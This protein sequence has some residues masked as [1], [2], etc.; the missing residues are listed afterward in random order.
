M[1]ASPSLVTGAGG[2]IGRALATALRASG[3]PVRGVL[4]TSRQAPV[5]ELVTADLAT[6]E[7]DNRLMDGIDTVYHLAAKTHDLTDAAGV[8]S[9]YQRINVEG[10]RRLLACIHG[11]AIRRFVFISSVKAVGEGGPGPI[12]DDAPARPLTAYGRSKLEAEH[13]VLDH[14]RAH[15]FEAVVLRFPLVYG[16]GQR[17]NL[18]RMIGS[19]ERGWFPVPPA[20]RNRRS[21]LHVENAVDA[22]R[23][24]GAHPSAAGQTYT[25]ADARPYETREIYDL[26]RQALGMSPA[27]WTV[28]ASALR[29]AAVAGDLARR[30][31]GRRVGFDSDAL[32]KLLGSAWYRGDRITRDLGFV[33]RR[34]LPGSIHSLVEDVRGQR[35]S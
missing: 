11:R 31:V 15:G 7:P 32:Q 28:P 2:F 22:L 16:V 5:D 26:I 3:I 21:M 8:E 24:A 23:L 13:L 9:E 18:Q 34:D 19:I 30:V 6:L 4:R 17:G 14:A 33:P 27:S 20:N 25:V 35:H 12:D 10:T 1:A 29:A